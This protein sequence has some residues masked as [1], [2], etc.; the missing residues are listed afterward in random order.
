MLPQLMFGCYGTMM[1]LGRHMGPITLLVA[2]VMC[3]VILGP[4]VSPP[5]HIGGPELATAAFSSVICAAYVAVF[6]YV[7]V[8]DRFE[9]RMDHMP[10]SDSSLAGK[11]ETGRRASVYKGKPC[12][13]T[14]AQ[15]STISVLGSHGM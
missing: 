9:S 8:W 4:G 3:A 15:S 7:H 12:P 1:Q 5:G 2:G 14:G 10:W 13:F 6:L 11:N